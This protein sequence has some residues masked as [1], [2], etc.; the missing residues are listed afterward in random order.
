MT[1]LLRAGKI[2][3]G[4]TNKQTNK[5]KHVTSVNKKTIKLCSKDY[6]CLKAMSHTQVNFA[7]NGNSLQTMDQITV[8]LL[9]LLLS[10]VWA[11]PLHVGTD[12]D[13]TK[14]VSCSLKLTVCQQCKKDPSYTRGT[15]HPPQ[16]VIR[17]AMR[18]YYCY[19]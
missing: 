16:L 2:G 12:R 9:S 19:M 10:F 13:L 14:S 18:C 11:K 8:F 4:E 6:A 5:Q 15:I 17:C 3:E 1:K 7:S